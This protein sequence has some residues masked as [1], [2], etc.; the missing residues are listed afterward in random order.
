MS[1]FILYVIINWRCGALRCRRRGHPGGV[2]WLHGAVT[3]G[4]VVPGVADGRGRG[5]GGAL[6]APACAHGPWQRRALRRALCPGAAR[7][8]PA[9]G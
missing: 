5:S 4:R 9:A 3:A 6:P 1:F 8:P 7:L 2:P